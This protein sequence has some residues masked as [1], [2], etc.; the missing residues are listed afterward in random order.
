[1]YPGRCNPRVVLGREVERRVGAVGVTVCGP[2]AFADDVR[3]AVRWVGSGNGG[4]G[5]GAGAGLSRGEGG[6]DPVCDFVEESFTW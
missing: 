1:M 6:G 4:A 2:G 3:D 5:A